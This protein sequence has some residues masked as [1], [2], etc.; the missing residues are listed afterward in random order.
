MPYSLEA[1][2][3]HDSLGYDSTL[4]HNRSKRDLQYSMSQNM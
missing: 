4:L 2:K 3:L 1:S